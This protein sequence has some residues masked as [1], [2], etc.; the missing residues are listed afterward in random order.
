M[1]MHASPDIHPP[2]HDNDLLLGFK[3]ILHRGT[4]LLTSDMCTGNAEKTFPANDFGDS[5]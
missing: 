3:S 1:H 4:S 2:S 5:I